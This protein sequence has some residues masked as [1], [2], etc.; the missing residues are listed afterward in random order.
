[1]SIQATQGS[2]GFIQ[3]GFMSSGAGGAPYGG[4]AA[5]AYQQ[6]QANAALNQGRY[7][8]MNAALHAMS[9][10]G[11]AA[12]AAL[13]M[14]GPP[15][16]SPEESSWGGASSAGSG[17]GDDGGGQAGSPGDGKKAD[18]G[19]IMQI[20]QAVLPMI[21]GIAGGQGGAG[22]IA[23]ALGGAASA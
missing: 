18:L 19:G 11:R 8:G 1:M 21:A 3:S 20:L 4:L 13:P 7:E 15:I 5:G 22:A 12:G 9:D 17:Q 23:S 16:H 6:G 2:A 14:E 10:G